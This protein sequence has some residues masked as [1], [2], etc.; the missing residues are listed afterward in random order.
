MLYRVNNGG[1]RM[2]GSF[3]DARFPR[4]VN[5]LPGPAESRRRRCRNHLGIFPEVSVI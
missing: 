5:L 3:P 4:V 2:P 1:H